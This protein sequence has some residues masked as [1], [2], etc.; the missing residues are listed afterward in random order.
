VSD[1][2]EVNAPDPLEIVKGIGD[3][4]FATDESGRIV[5]WNRAAEKLLGHAASMVLGHRCDELL[6]GLDAFG[7]RYC[8]QDC[9]LQRI[10]RRHESI[11]AFQLTLKTSPGELL[12]TFCSVITVRG[13][14]SGQFTLIHVLQPAHDLQTTDVLRQQ[15]ANQIGDTQAMALP[16]VPGE[17]QPTPAAAAGSGVSLTGREVEI[18]RL[19]SGGASAREIADHLY[20][21]VT[22]VRT[23]IRN[24][25]QKL[26]VHTKVQAVA[27]ALRHRLI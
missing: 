23:H 2:D 4:A 18:L 27:M 8:D 17:S 22:T 16:G 9:N 14:R 19:A 21:S 15:L 13:P 1:P 12:D 6:C 3:A 7:N 25:L 10:T 24:I 11:H 20:I 26:D 5:I